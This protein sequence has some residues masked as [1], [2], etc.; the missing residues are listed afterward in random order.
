MQAVIEHARHFTFLP[1]QVG[2]ANRANE[3]GIAR[4]VVPWRIA[5]A[6]I[7]YQQADACQLCVPVYAGS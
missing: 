5:A 7:R 1:C 6:P 4:D 2:S 3:E